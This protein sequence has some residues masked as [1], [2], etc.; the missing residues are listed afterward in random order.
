MPRVYHKIKDI[1]AVA[2]RMGGLGKKELSVDSLDASSGDQ[3]VNSSV[4]AQ[5]SAPGAP[6][7]AKPSRVKP[8]DH[9]GT[10]LAAIV[11]AVESLRPLVKAEDLTRGI[12]RYRAS[13]PND[14]DLAVTRKTLLTSARSIIAFLASP[15]SVPGGTILQAAAS[16]AARRVAGRTTL[17]EQQALDVLPNLTRNM[18]KGEIVG[19]NQVIE[20]AR[21]M[22][23]LFDVLRV[24]L[25]VNCIL[26]D[27]T[28]QITTPSGNTARWP[29]IEVAMSFI[30]S[31]RSPARG[32]RR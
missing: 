32:P 14:P 24:A 22:A 11:A 20:I 9:P 12:G 28:C 6:P 2:K 5:G 29:A 8:V 31:R 19:S 30:R 16:A 26:G 18:V 10:N 3:H 21:V 13:D 15:G 17:P 4:S 25:E 1:G 27:G 7:R 23:D